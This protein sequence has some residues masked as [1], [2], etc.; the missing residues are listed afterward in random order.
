MT[1]GIAQTLGRKSAVV[2]SIVL[3]AVGGALCGAA[4]NMNMLIGGRTV[5]GIGGGGILSFSATRLADI[6][7]P[8]ER[9][10]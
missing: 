10:L 4:Q 2:G 8:N 5:Q 1:G 7:P 3:F 6:T 9:G